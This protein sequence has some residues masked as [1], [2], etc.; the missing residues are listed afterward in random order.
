MTSNVKKRDVKFASRTVTRIWS[1]ESTADNPYLA[2]QCRCQGY[3][4]LELARQRSFVEVLFLLFSG[5]LPTENQVGLLETLMI[6]FI[7]P[8][9]RHPATRAAMNTGV[10][11]SRPVHILPIGLSVMGGAH[12]GGEETEAAMRYIRKH[13]RIDPQ[14]HAE[15]LLAENQR[16]VEGDWHIIPG[17]GSRFGGIDPLPKKTAQ[18]L[19]EHP[20]CGD[21]IRWGN[22]FCKALSPA[23]LGWL[24]PGVA[25]A[26]FCDLGFH[27]RSGG[28][29]FQL[30]CAPGILAHGLE[31]ANK[32]INAM[33]FLDEENYIITNRGQKQNE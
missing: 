23:G 28:G 20:G 15:E 9:P 2:E 12:L 19:Q 6:A 18:L 10:G 3:D 33:P 27:P 29:L 7:N 25:A 14:A 24:A 21:S 4:I 31:M 11:K 16:P 26:V 22:S 30:V 13:Q 32:P 8:G 1:E 17:F 5:E